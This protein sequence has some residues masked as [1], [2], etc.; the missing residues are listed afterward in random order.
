MSEKFVH[1]KEL[2]D[3]ETSKKVKARASFSSG[4]QSLDD[5]IQRYAKNGSK[6]QVGQTHLLIEEEPLKIIGYY[7]LSTLS[8][9]K[10][11]LAKFTSYPAPEISGMLMARLAIATSEQ[12]KGHGKKLLVHALT[13]IQRISEDAAVKIV[14]VDALD[15]QAK[16]YYIQFGF[17]EFDNEPM[18]LFIS[19]E[20]VNS[21]LSQV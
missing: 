13:K 12:R 19:I 15:Q 4:K 11:L 17:I 6:N 9:E 10:S 14:V 1:I 3:L 7:T 5:Y 2:L 16:D 20:T 18:K 21:V 8:V